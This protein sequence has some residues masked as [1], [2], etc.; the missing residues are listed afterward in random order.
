MTKFSHG[1]NVK[2]SSKKQNPNKGENL[3]RKRFTVPVCKYRRG[4]KKIVEGG[5]RSWC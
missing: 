2:G 5:G 4:R 3:R 1:G